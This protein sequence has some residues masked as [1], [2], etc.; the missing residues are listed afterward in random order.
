MQ[1]LN[2]CYINDL[3]PGLSMYLLMIFVLKPK[4]NKLGDYLVSGG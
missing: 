1:M 4:R 2:F 3:R